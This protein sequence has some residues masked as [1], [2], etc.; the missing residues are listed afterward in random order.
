MAVG[1]IMDKFGIMELPV[2]VAGTEVGT[3]RLSTGSY[4]GMTTTVIAWERVEQYEIE[5]DAY[6][7]DMHDLPIS[8]GVYG[9]WDSAGL[10]RLD[11]HRTEIMASLVAQIAMRTLD[12]SG[13]MPEKLYIYR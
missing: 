9:C 1:K 4:M 12:S 8:S 13:R 7:V 10:Q 5:Q 6:D 3:L 2:V 11:A